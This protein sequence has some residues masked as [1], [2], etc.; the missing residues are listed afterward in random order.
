MYEVKCRITGNGSNTETSLLNIK[1]A[2]GRNM[3]N[4]ATDLEMRL[5]GAEKLL[6]LLAV[7]P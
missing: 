5:N 6:G 3:R 1:V 7:P 4:D 2:N